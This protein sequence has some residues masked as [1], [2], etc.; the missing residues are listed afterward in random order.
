MP[1]L[2][3][4]RKLI[5][6]VDVPVTATV[7]VPIRVVLLPAIVLNVMLAADVPV[8]ATSAIAP[9]W[10]IS[11]LDMKLILE[12]TALSVIAPV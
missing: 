4:A 10:S 3:L 5:A 8:L 1:P 7:P 12:P 2:L 9:F 11:L 6:A